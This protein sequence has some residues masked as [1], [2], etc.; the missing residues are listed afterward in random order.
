MNALQGTRGVSRS[1]WTISTA[2]LALLLVAAL[3]GISLSAC[4]SKVSSSAATSNSPREGGDLVF[5]MDSLGNDWVPNTSSISSFQGNI[6]GD[7]TDKL[8]YVDEEGNISPWIAESWD[9]NDDA[10]HFTLHLKD[11]VTFSD[12]EAVDAQAVVDNINVWANGI[13]D[14]GIARVGLFPSANYVGATA[15]DPLTVSVDFSEPTLGFIPTLGYHGSI[16]ISPRTL[17]LPAEDQADLSNVAGSGP[18]TVESWKDADHVKI[19]RRDDY[20]WGPEARGHTG[21]PYLD[22]VTYKQVPEN[23]LRTGSIQA[24]QADIAYNLNPLEL[25]NLKDKGYEI[26]APRYLGFTQGYA[27]NTSVAPFDDPAVRRAILTGIDRDEI[28]DTIYTSDWDLPESFIQ[29]N[30]PGASDNSERLQFDPDKAKKLLDDAGWAEGP[31][32]V[33]VKDGKKLEFTLYP[34]PYVPS[35]KP[36]DELVSQ[37]LGALGIDTDIQAYDVPT[38]N[39]NISDAKDIG[40][41]PISRSFVDAGT[42]AGVI[43]GAKEGDEDWFGVGTSDGRLNELSSE[44]AGTA[45]PAAR[46]NSLADLQD[47]ILEQAYFIPL[48]QIVQRIYVTNPR[49]HDVTFNGLAYASFAT[50]WLDQ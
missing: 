36:V 43:T 48:V 16:L 9:Q 25:D 8:I 15:Q 2:T 50:S 34:N 33:R 10:T 31:D 41:K 44:V 37:Q 12:G 6:W 47:Y 17:E 30:V 23:S 46:D 14:Q 21:A 40:A 18:F 49:L 1:R 20:D 3:A 13:P 32:G 28:R 27:L 4:G 22:S 35:T 45:D 38:Y 26:H 42:V 19:V 7:I 5:Q 11:G 39:K 29:S 24:G